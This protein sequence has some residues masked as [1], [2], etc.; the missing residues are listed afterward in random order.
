MDFI[1]NHTSDKHPWFK[2]SRQ[3][4]AENQFSDYY[5][6]DAGTIDKDGVRQPPNNWVNQHL[7]LF[8]IDRCFFP[9][10]KVTD[11]P[12]HIQGVT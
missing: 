5:T 10:Y 7:A 12:F 2:K 9:L 6:W 3:G 1:P 4:G 8:N 11:T